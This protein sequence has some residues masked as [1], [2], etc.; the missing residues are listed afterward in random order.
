[1]REMRVEAVTVLQYFGIVARSG[2]AGA[3]D[4]VSS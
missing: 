2:L 3:F 4:G 1:M